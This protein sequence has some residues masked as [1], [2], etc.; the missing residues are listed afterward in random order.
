M[1][2]PKERH[3]WEKSL[4]VK[5]A[6]LTS[7]TCVQGWT[8]ELIRLCSKLCSVLISNSNFLLLFHVLTMTNLPPALTGKS[9]VCSYKN[10]LKKKSVN[11]LKHSCPSCGWGSNSHSFFRPYVPKTNVFVVT[12]RFSSYKETFFF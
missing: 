5:L 3:R 12:C 7:Q 4:G 1:W 10:H 2:Q 11:A 6:A 9:L 8:R